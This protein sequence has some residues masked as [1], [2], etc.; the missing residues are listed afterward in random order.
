MREK[1]N[2]VDYMQLAVAQPSHLRP[3]MPFCKA[4]FFEVSLLDSLVLDPS[5]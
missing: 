3:L 1:A 2:T 4:Y 5:F